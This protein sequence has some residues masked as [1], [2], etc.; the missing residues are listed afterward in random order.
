MTGR[1]I[2]AQEADRIG[3]LNDVVAPGDLDGAVDVLTAQ[4]AS[5]SPSVMKLGRDAFYRTWD[6]S[7]SEALSVLHPMLTVGTGLEDAEEG[8][9]AFMEKRDP[10]WKGR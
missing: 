8:I 3:F 6:M 5:A 7:A 2:D 10:E 1:R 4:L 9:T